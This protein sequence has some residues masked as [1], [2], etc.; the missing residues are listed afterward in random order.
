[1]FELK[2]THIVNAIINV[3]FMH[4]CLKFV[5]LVYFVEVT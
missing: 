4:T 5:W 3:K 1:M 2:S